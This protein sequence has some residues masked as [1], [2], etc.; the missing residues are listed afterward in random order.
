MIG[1]VSDGVA[2]DD[3]KMRHE[4]IIREEKEAVKIAYEIYLF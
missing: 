3:E 4:S 1:T 2:V